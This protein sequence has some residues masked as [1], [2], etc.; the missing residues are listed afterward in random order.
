MVDIG[1]RIAADSVEFSPDSLTAHAGDVLRFS[2]RDNGPHALVFD[3]QATDS[4]ARAFL[5]GTAQVR[6]LPLLNT[7]SKWI[8][9][10]ADA[11]AGFYAVRCLTH[12]GR[13][14]IMV[15]LAGRTR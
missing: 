1:V 2:A 3:E 14:A 4:A 11:P 10:L 12:G 13:A 15:V 6:S 9:S 8:V 7:S 5:Q